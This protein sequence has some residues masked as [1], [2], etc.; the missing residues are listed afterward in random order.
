MPPVRTDK[1]NR[2]TDKNNSLH[3]YGFTDKSNEGNSNFKATDAKSKAVERKDVGKETDFRFD[4][5]NLVALSQVAAQKTGYSER[6]IK[7]VSKGVR[8]AQ[9]HDDRHNWNGKY[10]EVIG[11]KTRKITFGCSSF[12]TEYAIHSCVLLLLTDMTR[13]SYHI[14]DLLAMG[15]KV[16][17]NL[18]DFIFKYEDVSYGAHNS[19]S[20]LSDE[21]VVRLAKAC[22]KLK[23]VQLQSATSFTDQSLLA[24]FEHCPGLTSLEISGQ[25]GYSK[26]HGS[27]IDALRQKPSWV[28]I[29]KKLLL[30]GSYDE[31]K[32]LKPVRDLTKAREGLV[33]K[34][35]SVSETKKWGDWELEKYFTTY[36]KGRKQSLW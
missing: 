14:D 33:V 27:S 30:P 16:C 6:Q 5:A 36:K 21:G 23:K 25:N 4:G 24:F 19:A 15:P 28:P 12:L 22:P 32:F 18:T 8:D 20:I 3:P 7:S 13:S 31:K 35:V 17:G 10:H 1:R 11:T 29:L 2:S 9:L 26:I 34:L